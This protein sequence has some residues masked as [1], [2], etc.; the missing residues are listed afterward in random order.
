M[1]DSG[2]DKLLQIQK[3]QQNRA[4]NRTTSV[5]YNKLFSL[6]R[7]LPGKNPTEYQDFCNVLISLPTVEDRRQA[8]VEHYGQVC[9]DKCDNLLFQIASTQV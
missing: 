9:A 8:I 2:I 3:D 7:S 5:L 6:L 4:Q 1:F